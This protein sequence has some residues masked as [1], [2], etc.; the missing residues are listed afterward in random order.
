[1]A[2]HSRLESQTA[3]TNSRTIAGP[4]PL[5]NHFAERNSVLSST[6]SKSKMYERSINQK[7]RGGNERFP[8]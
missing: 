5:N 6:F 4:W 3:R 1:M 8:L 7:N 2:Y